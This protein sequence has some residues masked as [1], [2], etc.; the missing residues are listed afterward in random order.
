L[1]AQHLATAREPLLG[2]IFADFERLRDGLALGP[3]L[4]QG[5][6]GMAQEPAR[7]GG[8]GGRRDGR[9]QQ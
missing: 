2:R 8:P 6:L 9:Q 1:I 3:L 4:L 7:P 5:L